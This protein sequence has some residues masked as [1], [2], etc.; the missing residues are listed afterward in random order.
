MNHGNIW[1]IAH[2]NVSIGNREKANNFSTFLMCSTF[3]LHY[4]IRG[5]VWLLHSCLTHAK[6]YCIHIPTET[7]Q[8]IFF[9]LSRNFWTINTYFRI[10]YSCDERY[11]HTI[12]QVFKRLNWKYIFSKRKKLISPRQLE[13]YAFVEIKK[14]DFGRTWNMANFYTRR[15][16]IYF[17][18]QFRKKTDFFDVF[19]IALCDTWTCIYYSIPVSNTL[20]FLVYIYQR[21]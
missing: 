18:I 11:L 8:P 6:F 7:I 4:A 3:L 16:S 15:S 21:R 14:Y 19:D 1:I 12:L 10:N 9:Q 17:F 20:R 2:F 13:Q 5:C